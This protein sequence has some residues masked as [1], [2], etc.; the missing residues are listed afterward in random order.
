MAD[1]TELELLHYKSIGEGKPLFI[2]HGLFGMLDNWLTIGKKLAE[3]YRVILVDLR[4]HGKSFHSDDCD[5]FLMAEDVAKLISHLGFE[6]VALLGHSMGGKVAMQLAMNEPDLIKQ[7]IVVD[8]APKTYPPGHQEVFDA[9]NAVDLD[10]VANRGE[11]EEQMRT[12]LDEEGVIQFLLKNLKRKKEGGYRWKANINA[13]LANYELIIENSLSPLY[14]YEEPTLFIKGGKSER[15]I[16]LSDWEM[17]L[18]L[19]PFAKLETVEKAGHW[20][21][22]EAPEDTIRLVEGFLQSAEN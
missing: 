3:K 21:H 10:N 14:S 2:L 5:Y 18:E 6:E 8:I 20:V 22:A 17:I 7:L 1:S 12:V 9:F 15:Y 4:N 13:M 16:E 11:A 19:F